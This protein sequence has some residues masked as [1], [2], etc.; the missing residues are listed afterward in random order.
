[1]MKPAA[2][3]TTTTTPSKMKGKSLP[4]DPTATDSLRPAEEMAATS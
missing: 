2:N 1:M 4:D 3:N